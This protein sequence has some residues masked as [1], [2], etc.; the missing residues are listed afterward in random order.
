MM[1]T[2]TVRLKDGSFK[3]EKYFCLNS[4]QCY[5]G[6]FHPTLVVTSNR[7]RS[8]PFCHGILNVWFAFKGGNKVLDV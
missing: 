1:F 4:L 7:P 5:Q 2:V 8:S 6:P 3:G